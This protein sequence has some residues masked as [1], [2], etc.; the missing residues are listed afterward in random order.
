MRHATPA[1]LDRIE[2]L[3]D[4]LRAI[5]GLKERKRGNFTRRSQAFLHFHEHEGE[6]IADVRLSESF[7]RY[8]VA[9]AAQ[10]RVLLTTIRDSLRES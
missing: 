3:L 9:T 4:K 5:D 1:D 8:P 6:L 2:P 7:D 10:Q